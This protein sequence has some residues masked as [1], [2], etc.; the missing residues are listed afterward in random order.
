MN[1]RHGFLS[2][3]NQNRALIEILC[4]RQ[5]ANDRQPQKIFPRLRVVHY[6]AHR[7][8]QPPEECHCLQYKNF[9]DDVNVAEIFGDLF[10]KKSQSLN[11]VCVKNF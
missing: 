10:E 6:R 4:R 1:E 5:R 8:F 11:F 3:H 7:E 2:K 9:G